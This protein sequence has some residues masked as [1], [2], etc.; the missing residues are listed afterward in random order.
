MVY[1][2]IERRYQTAAVVYNGNIWTS[3]NSGGTWIENTASRGVRK[4]GIPSPHRRRYQTRHAV[5]N[6]NIWT[7]TNSGGT[8]T[9]NTG[10]ERE[11]LVFHH[12]IE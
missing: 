3:T 10:G 6:G 5:C 2:L 11:R 8:W 7:S 9:E 12:L 1:H 4:T